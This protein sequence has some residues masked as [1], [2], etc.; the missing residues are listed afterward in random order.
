MAIQFRTMNISCLL[1][2]SHVSP[3]VFCITMLCYSNTEFRNRRYV[4][5]GNVILF[6]TL[7]KTSVLAFRVF[8]RTTDVIFPFSSISM[9]QTYSGLFC[10]VVNPYKMLPIYSDEIT[11]RYKGY[12]R[13]EN[14]PHVFA[15]ADTAYRSLSFCVTYSN[16]QLGAW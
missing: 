4:S 1:P 5:G 8:Q 11:E 16:T 15:I 2:F 6:C 14:P 9:F 10:V 12:K 7:G 3:F 13:H